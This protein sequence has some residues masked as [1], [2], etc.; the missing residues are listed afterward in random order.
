MVSD[1]YEELMADPSLLQSFAKDEWMSVHGL[2]YL[3]TLC[4]CIVSE[5]LFTHLASLAL[6]GKAGTH[7]INNTAR[8]AM[9]VEITP[10]NI[11]GTD[12]I[13]KGKLGMITTFCRTD[14]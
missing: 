3:H 1:C 6:W 9:S 10:L 7:F 8:R 12:S 2:P 11:L 14:Q 13:G 4:F 5:R